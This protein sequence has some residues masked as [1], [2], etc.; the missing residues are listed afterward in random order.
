MKYLIWS[1]RHREW[2]RADESGYT[3]LIEEAG[4]YDRAVAERIAAK[5]N[6]DGM[7]AESRVDPYTG[8]TY[9]SLP[10]HLV[11]APDAGDRPSV[12]CLCGSTRFYEEYLRA[13]YELT[14]AGH[15]VLSVGFYWHDPAGHGEGVGL[16]DSDV[17][18][19]AVK[20]SLDELHKRKID[21]ADS[22]LVVSDETGYLGDSTKSE[23]AYAEATGKPV[24]FV[25]KAASDRWNE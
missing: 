1:N 9:M 18:R 22:V 20:E 16:P 4:R 7:L 21:M 25:H 13:N 19:A 6:V 8:R 10:A 17:T 15:I 2:W 23:I 3:G 24:A 11:P 14:M 12:V 5:S